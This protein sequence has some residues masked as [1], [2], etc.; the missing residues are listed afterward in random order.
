MADRPLT[1][2]VTT[3]SLANMILDTCIMVYFVHYNVLHLP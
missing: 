1:W 2:V 3:R